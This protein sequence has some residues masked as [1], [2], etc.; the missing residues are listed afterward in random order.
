M[1]EKTLAGEEKNKKTG[2]IKSGFIP[3]F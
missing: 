1:G 3:N 2:F